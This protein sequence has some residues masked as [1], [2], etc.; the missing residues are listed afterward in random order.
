MPYLHNVNF[1]SS[2]DMGEPDY[3]ANNAQ[4]EDIINIRRIMVSLLAK[5][6]YRSGEGRVEGI[7]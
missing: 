1:G 3:Q 4:R 2:S 7:S 6:F 5:D